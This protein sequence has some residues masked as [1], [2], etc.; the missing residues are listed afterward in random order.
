[1]PIEQF[2]M[3]RMQSTWENLVDYDMS[4]SGVRPLTLRELVA[5][6]FDLESFLDVPLGY[7]QS[8]GTVE[9][10]ERIAVHYP[11]AG[12]DHVEVTN[13]TSEANYLIALSQLR[14]GDDVAMEVPNYMQMPG[15][16]RSFGATVKPFSLRQDTGWEPDWEEFER[17]VTPRTRILYLSNPNNPTGAVLSDAAMRR[18]AE[19]CEQT[20]TW[21]IA[22]EVYLGAE[23]DRPRTKSF[24]GM[25]DR[26]I[27]T[28]GLSKAYGIPGVRIGWLVAPPALAAECWTQHDY[29]TIGPN[30]MS[31][32][33]ARVA[34]EPSNRER[35]YARTREILRHNLPIARE[36][37]AGFGEILSWREP[38]AGA[39]ALL[40]YAGGVSSVELAERV[41]RNQNTL[42]VPGSHVGLEG[43]L[44]IW[45]GGREEFLREG[46]TRIGVELE[47]LLV[48][49]DR[50][51]TAYRLNASR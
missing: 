45:L 6:G 30:K 39:I 31:D 43:H 50:T 2:E 37:I 20:G 14:P 27:V 48:P 11:G 46:L 41:R 23:I 19:R 51:K 40:E 36:W 29:I 35:C 42:I 16:A 44:R 28:S 22:D 1:M 7:S 49:S 4:E 3:E 10:R 47:R 32:R 13:G 15:V 8:N 26:V 18:I 5:M 34:V 38:Q 9:L 25:S 24:W 21:L 12:V 33:I 17:A